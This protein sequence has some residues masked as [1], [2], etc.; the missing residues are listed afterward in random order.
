MAYDHVPPEV[1]TE[2]VFGNGR[3]QSV[4]SEPPEI[5]SSRVVTVIDIDDDGN[6]TKVQEDQPPR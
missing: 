1:N 2:F 4:S 6:V 5:P 3:T